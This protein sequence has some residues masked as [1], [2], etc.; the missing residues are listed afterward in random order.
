VPERVTC[1]PCR[2][3]ARRQFLEATESAELLLASVPPG[4][5]VWAAAKV[6]PDGLAEQARE[7]RATAARFA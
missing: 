4:D 3:H 7:Y 2:E 6:T 1:L 5:P